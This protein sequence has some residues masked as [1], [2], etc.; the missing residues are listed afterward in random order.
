MARRKRMLVSEG[1]DED[2]NLTPMLD[3]SIQHLF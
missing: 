1:S 3:E 2:I